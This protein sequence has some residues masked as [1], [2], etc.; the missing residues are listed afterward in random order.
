MCTSG[1]R[2][3]G[4]QLELYVLFVSCIKKKSTDKIIKVI[5]S[6]VWTFFK[7]QENLL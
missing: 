1:V 6:M 3:R 4:V 2:V 7:I 5:K